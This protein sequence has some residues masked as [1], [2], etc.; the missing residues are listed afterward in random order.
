MDPSA[1]APPP[2]P[3][4]QERSPL[5]SAS[6][7]SVP[8]PMAPEEEY[9]LKWRDYQSNFFA[10]AEDLFLNELLTDVTLCCRDQERRSQ[11]TLPFAV[12]VYFTFCQCQSGCSHVDVTSIAR[13]AHMS[14][15]ISWQLRELRVRST[16]FFTP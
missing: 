8:A 5:P 16:A 1:A 14:T 6:S 9:I 10:L 15:L 2:T 3:A 12:S 4:R 11:L 13:Y 7:S